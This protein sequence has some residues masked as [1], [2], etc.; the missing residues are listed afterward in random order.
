MEKNQD[1]AVEKDN[2]TGKQEALLR[3]IAE[4]E[5]ALDDIQ[6][7][8]RRRS[9]VGVLGL[10]LILSALLMFLNN[11]FSF[12]GGKMGD[13]EF[14]SALASKAI[15]DLKEVAD[16]NPNV[17]LIIQDLKTK[18]MPELYKQ[19]LERLKKET[20]KIKSVG[21]EMGADIKNHLETSVKRKLVNALSESIAELE[22]VLR[23]K[24]P[25]ISLKQLHSIIN[26]AKA[27]FIL[28]ITD[29]IE[30]RLSAVSGDI[31]SLKSSVERFKNCEEYK[32]LDPDNEHTIHAV[33]NQMVEAM[34][35]LV[36]YHLNEAKGKEPV[37]STLAPVVEGGV[38]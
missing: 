10:L 12:A 26:S 30:E 19:V 33:K 2:S 25:D 7:D 15:D 21:E 6:R 32:N 20:P 1:P 31:V 16:S 22:P 8:K 14:H 38:Q 29:I 34:L 5:D 18:I 9:I 13:S 36:I 17:N 37:D 28:E 3:K 27:T 11:V 35:E 23:E 24:Y 4:M